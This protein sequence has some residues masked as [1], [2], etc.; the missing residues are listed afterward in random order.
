MI[1]SILLLGL[2]LPLVSCG[3]GPTVSEENA[4]VEEVADKVREAS[5]D[6]GLIR[7]GKWV[8]AVTIEEVS[9]PGMPPEAAEQMQ[10]M[11]TRTRS[12][13]SC[14]T[15]ED[16]KQPRATFFAGNDK[17]RYDRFEM[18][19]GKIDALMRCQQDGAT[20]VMEM[21]GTYSPSSYR[22]QMSSKTEAGP[23]GEPMTMQMRVEAERIGECDEAS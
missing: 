11:L 13:E 23:G 14:L 21:T 6:Q 4:S 17:C 7:P 20:Q 1:R 10:G 16:A 12:A 3:P 2:A 15:E 22:M 5:K 19:S 8:S 9:I 18:S